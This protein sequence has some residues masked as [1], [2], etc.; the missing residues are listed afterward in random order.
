MMAPGTAPKTTYGILCKRLLTGTILTLSLL[1]LPARA[2]YIAE[3]YARFEA[4]IGQAVTAYQGKQD[5]AAL[6]AVAKAHAALKRFEQDAV[7]RG[8]TGSAS[9]LDARRAMQ[10]DTIRLLSALGGNY[11]ERKDYVKAL[12][13]YQQSLAIEP[14]LPI[15]HH[16]TAFLHLMLEQPEQALPHLYE[17]KRLNRIPVM[18]W[19]INPLNESFRI[20]ADAKALDAE[21]DRLLKQ[22]GQ[23]MD[24]PLAKDPVSG[25]QRKGVMV[26]GVGATLRNAAGEYANLYLSTPEAKLF[27]QFGQSV[28]SGENIMPVVQFGPRTNDPQSAKVVEKPLAHY[29]FQGTSYSVAL[30]T[31]AKHVFMIEAHEPGYSLRINR[32]YIAIG[33]PIA[34]VEKVLGQGF[35]FQ[36]YDLKGATVSRLLVYPGLGLVIG[37][38][39]GKVAA[40][41]IQ[42]LD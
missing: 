4:E 33:D 9:F 2:D 15:M 40:L 12:S 7:A 19:L 11:Y 10:V 5:D 30:N 14:E 16:Y 34:Q 18:R 35:G 23:P 22:L 41:N 8:Q 24:Y 31:A 1:C 37:I 6:A 38:K 39:D 21:N 13:C 3:N 20:G 27:Q 28:P 29:P 26:P 17:A 42:S 36:S 32:E 25:Q